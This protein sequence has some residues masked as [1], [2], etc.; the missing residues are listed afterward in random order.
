MFFLIEAEGEKLSLDNQILLSLIQ[1]EKYLH[2]YK[3]IQNE[4]YFYKDQND[5]KVLKQK[6]AFPIEFKDAIPLGT[7]EFTENYFKIFYGIEKENPIEIPPILRTEEFLKRKYSITSY[8][9]IPSKGQY[10]IKDVSKLKV[11]S[12]DGDMRFFVQTDEKY[13]SKYSLTLN[14]AHLYQV[15]E[16][17]NILSEYRIFV[18]D[19]EIYSINNY[20]G[21][22]CLFPDIPLIKKAILLWST[23][24][25]CPNSYSLDVAI[26]P[27]G[28]IILECHILF[29][30]GIY[31]TVNGTKLLY[32]YRDAK[33]YLLKYNTPIQTFSNFEVNN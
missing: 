23:Q 19:N 33:D 21:D 14:P 3:I 32:G 28:T 12:Y 26:T 27:L 7:I 6:E 25:D 9:K 29:S 8:D 20:D 22:V 16:H 1:E 31:S 5:K 30:T 4:D 13:K 24:K 10:F 18:L 2:T 11:F 15:S 17:V